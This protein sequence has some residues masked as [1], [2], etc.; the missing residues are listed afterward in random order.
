MEF[1]EQGQ[2]HD[3]NQDHDDPWAEIDP[4]EIRQYVPDGPQDRL[5]DPI[6]E[7]ADRPDEP[8]SRVQ[9]TEAVRMLKIAARITAHLNRL[10][11]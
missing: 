1:E 10:I 11:T 3:L 5:G 4:A 8:V 2:N 6:E 7:V 9:H